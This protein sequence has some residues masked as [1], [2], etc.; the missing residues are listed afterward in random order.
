MTPRGASHRAAAS[1]SPPRAAGETNANRS[2]RSGRFALERGQR[3]AVPLSNL[4][5]ECE[6]E[7][8]TDQPPSSC[9]RQ[10]GRR[11]QPR[12]GTTPGARPSPCSHKQ[13]RLQMRLPVSASTGARARLGADPSR[14]QLQ[15][16]LGR[17]ELLLR[18]LALRQSSQVLGLQL[19]L[20]TVGLRLRNKRGSGFRV[21]KTKIVKPSSAAGPSGNQA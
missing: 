20:A 2:N 4:L 8:H 5:W 18:R 9:P 19:L 21:R 12:S 13:P 3:L 11:W 10:T 6:N 14:G 15:R 17:L 1:C 16:G 7:Y